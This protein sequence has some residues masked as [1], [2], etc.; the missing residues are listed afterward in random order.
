[1]IQNY[2]RLLVTDFYLPFGILVYEKPMNIY[3]VFAVIWIVFF[4]Y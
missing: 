1:M 3:N 2:E 4:V